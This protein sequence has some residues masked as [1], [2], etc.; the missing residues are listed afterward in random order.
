MRELEQVLQ[1]QNADRRRLDRAPPSGRARRRRR[2]SARSRT[3]RRPGRG[4][5][6]RACRAP[7][8]RRSAPPPSAIAWSS[9]DSPSRTEPSAARA[10]R[11]SAA[12]AISTVLGRG[13][14]P[15]MRDELVDRHAA[16]REALAARQ[17]RDR[18]FLDLGGGEDEFDVGRRLFERLQ[19]RVEGVLRQH[20]HF[21]DDVDLEARRHRAVAHA[22]GQLADVVDA[23][24][25]G[26]VHLDHVDMA[27]LGDRAARLAHAARAD[28]SGRPCRRGRCS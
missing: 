16:Q 13:D 12:G 19:Q 17:H 2:P 20:V 9:S 18:H 15:V 23:G 21:V 4:R 10:I 1:H 5:R 28:R 7:S 8:P 27:V 22:L 25:R 14:L 24:A 3:D 26:G 11:P 6:C